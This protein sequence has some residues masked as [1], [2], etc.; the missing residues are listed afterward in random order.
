MPT[1]TRRKAA[2]MK[3]SNSSRQRSGHWTAS[4]R[5]RRSEIVVNDFSPPDRPL[6]SFRFRVPASSFVLTWVSSSAA[7]PRQERQADVPGH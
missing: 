2:S 3:M 6:T 1:E 4:Q 7:P 5:V